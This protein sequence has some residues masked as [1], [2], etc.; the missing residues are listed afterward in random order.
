M[1][2]AAEV[3]PRLFFVWLFLLALP[4]SAARPEPPST[5]A[6]WKR[7]ARR[8]H[9][10]LSS[11]PACQPIKRSVSLIDQSRS[12]TTATP[13]PAFQPQSLYPSPT[14][15]A[16]RFPRDFL[17]FVLFCAAFARHAPHRRRLKTTRRAA[18][19]VGQC[20]KVGHQTKRGM[21]SF[22]FYTLSPV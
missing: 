5:L 4:P 13:I 12:M 8:D 21:R 19:L 22:I 15:Q 2:E 3:R 20:C 11:P 14:S 6:V 9:T 17:R 1:D 7:N 10:P 18:A 16:T